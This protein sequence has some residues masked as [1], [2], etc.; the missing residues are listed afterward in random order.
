MLRTAELSVGQRRG[1][2]RR[3]CS[4]PACQADNL[5]RRRNIAIFLAIGAHALPNSRRMAGRVTGSGSRHR[6]QHLHRAQSR[7]V[8]PRAV[9]DHAVFKAERR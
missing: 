4:C 6:D 9:F 1:S 2:A 7:P 3:G 8:A 5:I